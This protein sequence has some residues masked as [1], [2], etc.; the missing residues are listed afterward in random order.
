MVSTK[1]N[2]TFLKISDLKTYDPVKPAH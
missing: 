2:Q 1:V